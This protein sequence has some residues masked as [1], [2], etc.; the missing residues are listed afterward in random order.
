MKEH[1]S[2]E[3]NKTEKCDYKN[4]T[5]LYSVLFNKEIL[6]ILTH[7][8]VLYLLSVVMKIGCNNDS[9]QILKGSLCLQLA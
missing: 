2:E 3:I 8:A 7:F 4:K 5:K 6:N 1:V 9:V